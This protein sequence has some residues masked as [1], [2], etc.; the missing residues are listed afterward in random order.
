[1]IRVLR[2]LSLLLALPVAASALVVAPGPADA[3]SRYD[4]SGDVWKVNVTS[5]LQKRHPAGTRANADL[6]GVTVKHRKRAVR[7]RADYNLL[8][9]DAG[10]FRLTVRLRDE[11]TRTRTVYVRV[12]PGRS[13]ASR[14]EGKAGR[15]RR[16]PGLSSQ[17]DFRRDT[18]RV[19]VPRRCLGNPGW[20]RFQATATA[21]ERD[22]R[23][24]ALYVDD[25]RSTRSTPR[26]W[27]RR[28]VRR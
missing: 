11:R 7:V 5:R 15:D 18:L 14:L 4:E 9:T 25:A 2:R 6:R 3:L 27:S 26:D 12:D 17:V 10:V 16:C 22:G 20:V 8:R 24:I 21:V 13:R 19:R 28:L 23:R 1:M